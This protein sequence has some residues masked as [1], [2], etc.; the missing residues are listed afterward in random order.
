MRNAVRIILVALF[1]VSCMTGTLLFG[2]EDIDR[3][4]ERGLRFEREGNLDE[5]VKSYEEVI[6]RDPENVMIRI[7]LAKVLSWQ[8]EFDRALVLLEE[9]LERVPDSEEALFRKA[10]IKSWKGEYEESIKL[11]R[12][13]LDLK[14]NDPNGMLGLARVLF[15]SG[16]YDKAIQYFEKALS[17]GAD[18]VEVRIEL[19]KVY[20][21]SNDRKKAKEEFETVL[22]MDPKNR[23]AER[24]L[25]GIRLEKTYELSPVNTR[26]NVYPD[27]SVGVAFWSEFV[28]HPQNRWDLI[29]GFEHV[30]LQ[31]MRDASIYFRGVYRGVTDLYLRAGL[32][33]T[34]TPSFSPFLETD[35]G[36]SYTF[37]K[38]LG[39]GLSFESDI[40]EEETLFAIIP[41]IRKDFTDLT[42]V[43]LKYYYYFYTTGYS[44]SRIELIL[45]LEYMEHNDL[46]IKAAYGGDVETR[47]PARRVFDF[48]TGI[49]VSLTDQI[50]T[51]L[52]F[53]WVETLYGR[54]S[55]ISWSSYIRW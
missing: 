35:L 21:A 46:F 1:F 54:S 28:Y 39:A 7:R 33:A 55:E 13:F 47:D 44:A 12:R 50:E 22:A 16:R 10:Q 52:S 25:K 5:A 3:Y 48:A 9:V 30:T 2:Q 14:E 51:S 19:G 15:W 4:I 23:E 27:S 41:E 32:V 43:G 42:W 31:D 24:F 18:E 17:S 8:N 53:A 40:Y 11:Y 38:I 6:S 29:F 26:I 36:V 34:P 37:G 20:L 49:S 45:N